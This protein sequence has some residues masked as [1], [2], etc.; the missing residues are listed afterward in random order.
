MYDEENAEIE[1]HDVE[2]WDVARLKETLR[3]FGFHHRAAQ[4]L[5][6]PTL[7]SSDS[8]KP[9]IATERTQ[10]ISAWRR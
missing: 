2:G 7:G 4:Q 3:K 8:G 1:R 9:D 6:T 5:P 10:P